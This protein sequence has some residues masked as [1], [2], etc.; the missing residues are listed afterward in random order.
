MNIMKDT[1]EKALASSAENKDI[2]LLMNTYSS[3]SYDQL[4][5]YLSTINPCVPRIINEILRNSPEEAKLNF[6]STFIDMRTMKGVLS[7]NDARQL[8]T[9]LQVTDLEQISF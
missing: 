4:V 3:K 5:S 7:F 1:L 9:S 8:L 6:I 2:K